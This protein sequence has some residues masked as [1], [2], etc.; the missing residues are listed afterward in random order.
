MDQYLDRYSNK[1][2]QF[3]S[4][5]RKPSILF[6]VTHSPCK[7]QNSCGVDTHSSLKST[8][9]TWYQADPLFGYDDIVGRAR[10]CHLLHLSDFSEKPVVSFNNGGSSGMWWESQDKMSVG[11]VWNVLCNAGF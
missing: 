2:Q 4:T 6:L 1:S 3:S 5:N 11:H 9:T 10:I 8:V 7:T